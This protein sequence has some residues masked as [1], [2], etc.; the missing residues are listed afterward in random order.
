MTISK[1]WIDFTQVVKKLMEN[2]VINFDQI[3]ES[4]LM[5][6]VILEAKSLEEISRILHPKDVKRDATPKALVAGRTDQT[7]TFSEKVTKLRQRTTT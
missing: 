2:G 7:T 3:K 4:T 6:L 5:G 1:T